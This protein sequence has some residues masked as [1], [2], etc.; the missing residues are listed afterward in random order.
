MRIK[1]KK[2]KKTRSHIDPSRSWPRDRHISALNRCPPPISRAANELD[3]IPA[4]SISFLWKS[5]KRS[6]IVKSCAHT[7][8]YIYL[9]I[10]NKFV[11]KFAARIIYLKKDCKKKKE[12]ENMK[13][14]AYLRTYELTYMNFCLPVKEPPMLITSFRFSVSIFFLTLY[15]RNKG[16]DCNRWENFLIQRIV[17]WD[18]IED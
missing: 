18:V 13:V 17:K 9:K 7:H 3:T 10:L 5:S 2:K 8:I 16:R 6:I 11:R 15:N 14:K 1:K 4:K 12:E